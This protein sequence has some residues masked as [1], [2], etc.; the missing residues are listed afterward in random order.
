MSADISTRIIGTGKYKADGVL[1]NFDL[2][3]M[4]DTSDQ[5]ITERTGISERRVASKG[6]ATSDMAA[7]A[8]RSALNMA[9]KTANDLDMIICGTVTGDMP[10]PATAALIQQKIGASNMCASFDVSAAC[11][12][13][14]YGLSVADAFIKTGKAKN[15]AVIGA[16]MLTRFMDF[17]DRNTCVL[18]G[19]GAGAVI[20]TADNS[21]R[22]ILSTHLFTDSSLTGALQ[23]P[24]GGSLYPASEKTISSKRHY[25]KMEGREVFKVAVKYLADA[26]EVAIRSNGVTVDDIDVVA[27]HQA[28][29]RILSAVSKRV[30]IPI[31]K[32]ALNLRYYGNTSSASIPIS[33]DEAVRGGKVSDN[34]LVLMIAL[35]GGISWGSALIK[36]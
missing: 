11:A 23:I 17:E 9:G 7:E 10:L 30:N 35:G 5:W 8:V 26:A 33:L 19:D 31:E 18:F 2:E 3:K 1:T 6:I 29:M 28:N 13:F 32:F 25:I 15:I 20:V 4:V 36:W 22:G 21:S 27:A 12:G 14:I 24:G 34:N 16:E